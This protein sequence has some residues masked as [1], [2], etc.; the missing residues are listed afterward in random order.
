MTREESEAQ[1]NRIEAEAIACRSLLH[2]AA[3]WQADE[4][5]RGEAAQAARLEALRK[6]R[7]ACYVAAGAFLA[8][9]GAGAG[10][11]LTLP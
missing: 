11:V 8:A 1:M 9:A 4:R 3:Q 5:A 7:V 2:E 6:V 10:V